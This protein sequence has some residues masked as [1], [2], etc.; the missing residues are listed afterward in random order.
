MRCRSSRSATS[1]QGLPGGGS[2]TLGLEEER[3][4][5][6]GQ[7]AEGGREACRLEGRGKE[8]SHLCDYR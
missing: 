3:T 8:G 4:E 7:A 1:V 2:E 6:A 5:E